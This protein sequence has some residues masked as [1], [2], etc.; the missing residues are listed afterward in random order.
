MASAKTPK[1]VSR[2]RRTR[3]TRLEHAAKDDIQMLPILTP[4]AGIH[5]KDDALVGV[6][7]ESEAVVLFEV[8]E[9]QVGAAVRD[10]AGVVEQRGV[11]PAPD[12]PAILRLPENRVRSAKP[13]L[14]KSAQRVVAAERRHEVEG[15]DLAFIGIRRRYEQPRRDHPTAG[16]EPE[17]LAEI[18]IH[19][20]EREA[21]GAPVVHVREVDAVPSALPCVP[22]LAVV[23]FEK[24]DRSE[25]LDRQSEPGGRLRIEQIFDRRHAAVFSGTDLRVQR[26]DAG[27]DQYD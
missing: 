25:I 13:V 26:L 1:A 3:R 23:D 21:A 10:L 16:Q 20:V 27:A 5:P 7:A 22:G 19:A 24:A 9:I 4:K 2:P 12:L 14:A 18:G 11:E 17:E 6:E 15:H 8:V